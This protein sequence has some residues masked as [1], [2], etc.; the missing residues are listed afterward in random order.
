MAQ[1]IWY[2]EDKDE[3]A[4]RSTLINNAATTT[5]VIKS[6]G[7]LQQLYDDHHRCKKES[8]LA[9]Y[10]ELFTLDYGKA[11]TVHYHQ[12]YNWISIE[13]LKK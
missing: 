4:R 12:L 11:I 7:R 10:E 13:Q 8:K 3:V 5:R 1:S 9:D 6:K 2:L